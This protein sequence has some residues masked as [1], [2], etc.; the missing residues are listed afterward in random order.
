MKRKMVFIKGGLGL[1]LV[2]LSCY[3][4]ANSSLKIQ[5]SI[6]ETACAIDVGSRDQTIDMGS[7]PL[8]TIRQNGQ[9][10]SRIFRI[11]LIN[12]ALARQNSNKPNWQ[13]FQVTFDGAHSR[14]LFKIDGQAKGIGLQI[15]RD[16][17]EV[18]I[19][20]RRLSRQKLSEGQR[21]LLFQLR[22]IANQETLLSGRYA[23]Y[24]RFKLDYE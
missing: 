9:S 21:D 1:F 3:V 17:G 18:V 4:S 8:S 6:M 20:G 2:G 15:Q 23:S 16:D 5:G 13:Y 7:V 10:P 11:R 12:C 14:Q 22:L 19:P 24:I